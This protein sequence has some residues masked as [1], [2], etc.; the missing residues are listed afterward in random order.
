MNPQRRAIRGRAF[1]WAA[2][3]AVLAFLPCAGTLRAQENGA[4]AIEDTRAAL[5]KWVETRRVI[6]KEKKEQALA[7]ETLQSRIELMKQQIASVRERIAD[8]RKSIAD[9]EGKKHDLEEQEQKLD[10]GSAQLEKA[11]GPLETRTKALLQRLPHSLAEHLQPLSQ[12]IPDDP[13]KTKISLGQRYQNV[14]GILNEVNKFNREVSVKNEIRKLDGDTTAEVA[15]LY[16]GL[17]QAFYANTK[18]T[19]GGIGR[20]GPDGWNWTQENDA[21]KRIARAIAIFKNDQAASFVL[22]PVRIK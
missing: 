12:G 11:I 8:A 10:E 5:E 17:G 21:A 13:A 16:V 2:L 3:L 19:R 18:G 4:N 14:V 1:P 6:S 20:P 7:R 15:T 9:A 22:L